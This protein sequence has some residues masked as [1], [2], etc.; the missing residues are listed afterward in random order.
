V[1]P[2]IEL[3]RSKYGIPV[4]LYI[5]EK[6]KGI[7]KPAIHNSS[8]KEHN[9]KS[10]EK[11]LRATLF[12]KSLSASKVLIWRDQSQIELPIADQLI[13]QTVT[14]YY[15]S[16]PENYLLPIGDQIL[17]IKNKEL[18]ILREEDDLYYTL[19]INPQGEW[20]VSSID[21][22]QLSQWEDHRS[23]VDCPGEK[24]KP[25]NV[26]MFHYCKTVMDA[27]SK[28]ILKVRYSQ[29]CFI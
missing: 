20:R 29:G 13:P 2:A 27:D 5:T 26:F 19:A 15:E 14:V 8:C 23:E 17:F 7:F 10:G 1:G 21:L 4:E 11:I 3:Y 9:P 25:T 24:M 6:G 22:T 28:K 12:I 18:F 16:G